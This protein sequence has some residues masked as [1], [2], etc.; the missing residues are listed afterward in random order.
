MLNIINEFKKELN[1]S[2]SF[3]TAVIGMMFFLI[4]MGLFC[5]LNPSP[6]LFLRECLS[7]LNQI[8]E[9]STVKVA[10]KYL[11]LALPKCQKAAFQKDLDFWYD[12]LEAQQEILNS[13]DP[14]DSELKK[15]QILNL[16][17][18]NLKKESDWRN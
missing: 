4:S 14:E 13:T 2:D 1:S 11:D 16:V 5:W 17:L 18:S 6:P 12:N 7:N 10:Q 9:A 3:R 15:H 8:Q